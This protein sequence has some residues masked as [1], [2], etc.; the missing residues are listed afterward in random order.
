MYFLD[1]VIPESKSRVVKI[2]PYSLKESSGWVD[3]L[4]PRLAVVTGEV[5]DQVASQLSE[6]VKQGGLLLVVASEEP[7]FGS[8]SSLLP[9]ASLTTSQSTD[10]YALLASIDFSHPLFRPLSGPRFND[11][12]TIRYWKH[13]PI[14]VD[15]QTQ[16]NHVIARF[17]DDKVAIWQSRIE[18]G[19][20]VAMSSSWRPVDSQ[21]A[22]STK[23]VPLITSLLGMTETSERLSDSYLVGDAIQLPESDRPWTV[24]RPD[25][26]LVE[27]DADEGTQDLFDVPGVFGFANGDQQ[28]RVAVNIDPAESLTDPVDTAE[29]ESFD[30]RVGNQPSREELAGGLQKM[31]DKQLENRQRIWK[32]LL[33]AAICLLVLETLLAGKKQTN[34]VLTEAA[35]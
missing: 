10:E 31:K 28:F 9:G 22:L 11:F 14:D 6:Y 33:L 34:P 18:A 17:D 23:F 35:A 7:V 2:Q 15:E 4:V 21:L 1:R 30:V 20:V 24:T 16:D 19:N 25:R 3:G 12:T 32:W 26:K 29:L 13:L 27:L 5:S 8:L